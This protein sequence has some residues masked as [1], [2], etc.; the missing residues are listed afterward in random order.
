M[1]GYS[2]TPL[3][4]KLGIRDG[5]KVKF[6]NEPNYYLDLLDTVNNHILFTFN[7]DDLDFVHIFIITIDELKN[8]IEYLKK[9]IKKSGM[10][11]VSWP[12]RSRPF[13]RAGVPKQASEI[14]TDVTENKIRDLAL[15]SGLVD[16]KVCAVDNTW[17]GLKLVYRLKDR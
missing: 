15:S 16:V 10:I 17:S 7:E 1:A 12:A 9:L 5:Y 3:I 4:K 8:K 13:G 14:F 11:W 2:K 6:I